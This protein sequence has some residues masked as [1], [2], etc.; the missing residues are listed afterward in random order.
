MLDCDRCGIGVED[1][2]FNT[3]S[4]SKGGVRILSG[5][6]GNEVVHVL[7]HS[8]EKCCVVYLLQLYYR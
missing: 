5:E 8:L 4:G 3:S 2:I 7:T 1:A 6:S